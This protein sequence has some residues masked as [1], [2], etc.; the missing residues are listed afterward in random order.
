MAIIRLSCLKDTIYAPFENG[1]FDAEPCGRRRR[2]GR[3]ETLKQPE[4]GPAKALFRHYLQH[5]GSRL[6]G[7]LPADRPLVVMVHGFL[8]DPKQSVA[9][10]P[11][12]TDNPHGRVFHF[13]D[14][15]EDE[16][17]RHHTT[18]WPRWLGFQDTND[19]GSDGLV[20]A[21]GW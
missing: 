19:D 11:K 5:A 15:G 17:Q 13:K 14:S 1:N 9:G 6:S 20:I 3:M 7:P 12:E 18:A 8:F 2:R 16:E 21:F 4:T 10:D